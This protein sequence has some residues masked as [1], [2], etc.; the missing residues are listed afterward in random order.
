MRESVTTWYRGAG[1]QLGRGPLGYAIW[2]AGGPPEQ[3]LE[4]WPETPAGWS[5]AWAR[6][7]AVEAPGTIAHLEP[8]ADPA[9]APPGFP[10]APPGDPVS[11]LEGPVSAPLAG[12]VSGPASTSTQL[13]GVTSLS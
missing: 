13:P 5:A 7:N 8:P 6:F 10:A 1:Y 12:P 4:Q 3:P 9:A 2:L 11:P